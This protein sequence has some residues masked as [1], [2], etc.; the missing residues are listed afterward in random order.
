M[1]EIIEQEQ[2]NTAQPRDRK[3]VICPLC[4]H[5][6]GQVSSPDGE[7]EL[8]CG[9]CKSAI[10]FAIRNGDCMVMGH[11]RD[12]AHMMQSM[13]VVLSEKKRDTFRRN[14]TITDTEAKTAE[15]KRTFRSPAT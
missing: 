11:S 1:T 15:T 10:L 13:L 9:K 7:F 14:E 3:R 8:K 6:S 4:G 2:Q 5:V 12:F